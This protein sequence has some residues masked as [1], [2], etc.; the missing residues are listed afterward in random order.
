MGKRIEG[1]VD[2]S[3]EYGFLEDINKI[4]PNFASYDLLSENDE[5]KYFM[6]VKELF[7]KKSN[8]YIDFDPWDKIED[9]QFVR[10]LQK[11]GAVNFIKMPEKDKLDTYTSLISFVK[12]DPLKT[13]YPGVPVTVDIT[14]W[15]KHIKPLSEEIF[16]KVHPSRLINDFLGWSFIGNL[17]IPVNAAIIIDRYAFKYD[18]VIKKNLTEILKHLIPEELEGDFDLCLITDEEES[19]DFKKLKS[20]VTKEFKNLHKKCSLNLSIFTLFRNISTHDRKII[21]N[22]YII[23]SGNSFDYYF[24]DNITVD[25]SLTL[26]PLLYRNDLLKELELIRFICNKYQ[27]KIA[28]QNRI[29]GIGKKENSNK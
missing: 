25:T 4:I 28:S 17:K 2:V 5:W 16:F 18:N 13:S 21:T 19:M 6:I 3:C 9:D 12:E 8:L 20:L 15:I 10:F 14:N 24:N 26:T 11:S 27:P 7:E 1:R 29:L 22:Y 23:S